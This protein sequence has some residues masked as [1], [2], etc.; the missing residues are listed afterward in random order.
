MKGRQ[1][2][3]RRTVWGQVHVRRGPRR[4]AGH[5]AAAASQPGIRAPA[6]SHPTE[7]DC[8]SD[9]ARTRGT[10]AKATIPPCEHE[11]DARQ[12][13]QPRRSPDRALQRAAGPERMWPALSASGTSQIRSCALVH[14]AGLRAFP[15]GAVRGTKNNGPAWAPRADRTGSPRRAVEHRRERKALLGDRSGPPLARPAAGARPGVGVT[16][17]GGICASL[18]VSAVS[19]ALSPP[20]L[21]FRAAAAAAPLRNGSVGRGAMQ[22]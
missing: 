6:P 7:R 3:T 21:A 20:T 22:A 9:P 14:A 2:A 13:R 4:G 1:R 5:L 10:P 17:G 16:A 19:A 15:T 8:G 11:H 18:R 12:R